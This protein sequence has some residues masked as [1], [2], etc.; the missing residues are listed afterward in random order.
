MAT[1]LSRSVDS[2]P[3]RTQR[4]VLQRLR[5][6]LWMPPL[7]L[8]SVLALAWQVTAVEMPFL[9]PPLQDVAATLATELPYYLQNAGITLFESVAGLAIGFVVAFGLAVLTSESAVIRRA[10]MPVAVVLNVTPLVAIAPALVVAF[11]FGAAPKLI[12]TALICF[13]PILINTA[14]GLRSVPQQVLQVYRTVRASRLELL[15][16]VRVPSALPYVFAALRIVFPLSIIGAVVAELSAAGATGGLGTVISTAS[17][18]NQLAVV[19]ASIFILALLGVA[20]LGV[21]TLVERRVLRWHR[22]TTD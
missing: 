3:T 6:S 4:G 12:I 1:T 18:M 2:R 7:V 22:G 19:Y 8:I 10:V 17:S 20:L 14:T 16:H 13:F 5:I 11:G 9:L 21:I 15:L